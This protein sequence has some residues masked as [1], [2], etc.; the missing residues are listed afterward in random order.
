MFADWSLAYP[1]LEHKCEERVLGV[2]Q[3]TCPPG[4]F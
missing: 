1:S 2:G 4:P 3:Q